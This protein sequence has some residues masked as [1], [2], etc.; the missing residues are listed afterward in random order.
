[1]NIRGSFIDFFWLILDEFKT[2]VMATLRLGD[3][4]Q[5]LK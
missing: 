1:M 2:K 5:I 3:I 4:A